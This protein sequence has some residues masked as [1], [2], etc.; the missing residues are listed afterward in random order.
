MRFSFVTLLLSSMSLSVSPMAAGQ[1]QAPSSTAG[2]LKHQR[3]NATQR[4][5]GDYVPCLFDS[6]ETFELRALEQPKLQKDIPLDDA[7]SEAVV[8]VVKSISVG[9]A[10]PPAAR[11]KKGE[12]RP[13]VAQASADQTK[14]IQFADSLTSDQFVNLLPRDVEKK[15][16]SM[17]A[18]AELPPTISGPLVKLTK[19]AINTWVGG[20]TFDRPNDVSCSF[21][22]LQWKETSDNF[23][24]RVANDYLAIQVTVR[25]LN[26]QTEFLIHDVQIAVDTGLNPIQFGRFEAARDKLIVRNVAQRG[27][28]EDRRNLIINTLQA[29]GAIAGGASAAVTQS[30]TSDAARNLASA[31]AIFQ[32][33]FMTG[34]INIFPDHTLEHINHI[35]DLAFSASSSSKTIVPIQGSIPLVTFLSEKPLE[36]LP[37][38]RCGEATKKNFL[39]GDKTKDAEDATNPGGIKY[40]FCSIDNDDPTKQPNPPLQADYYMK[41]FPFRNWNA[42][43][44]AILQRRIFVVIGGVHIQEVANSPVVTKVSCPTLTDGTIDLSV[45]DSNGSVS[46]TLEGTHLDK[47]ASIKVEQG[48]T[49]KSGALKAASDGNSATI[50]FKAADF[51][52]ASGKY[53]LFLTDSSGA[54]LDTKQALNFAVRKPDVTNVSFAPGTLAAVNAGNPLTTTLTGT[55][56]DRIQAVTLS[57]CSGFNIKGA[58]QGT[59]KAT[60]KTMVVKFDL[61]DVTKLIAKLAGPP[62]VADAQLQFATVDNPTQFVAPPNNTIH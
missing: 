11:P 14:A 13:Q 43:A 6:Q 27:Q 4:P 20:T 51:A 9:L 31:V 7:T 45:V 57:C 16:Q 41:P 25:N 19:A 56:L 17:A 54:D 35:N 21:S 60:D 22:V 30:G 47:A 2:A 26:K 33:P 61:A 8:N 3:A 52:G 49:V 55:N 39:H 46:C 59:V 32:G 37:F 1:Q 29:A 62:V 53:E 10:T 50:G 44:I 38:S 48:S 36:Q 18:S 5:L 15:V 40:P 24:R 34:V 42:A 58:I 23:G 12:K 28:S